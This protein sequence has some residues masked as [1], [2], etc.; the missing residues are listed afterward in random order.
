MELNTY[1]WIGLLYQYILIIRMLRHSGSIFMGVNQPLA[2][3]EMEVSVSEIGRVIYS[4]IKTNKQRLWLP[5]DAIAPLTWQSLQE[6]RLVLKTFPEHW[7]RAERVYMPCGHRKPNMQHM[8]E[9]VA[10]LLGEHSPVLLGCTP[11]GGTEDTDRAGN[12]CTGNW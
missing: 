4:L 7:G 9:E 11:E 12:G 8:A 2:N 1:R 5:C 10:P 3:V 6:M